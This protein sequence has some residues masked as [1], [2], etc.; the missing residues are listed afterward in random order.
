MLLRT[1]LAYAATAIVVCGVPAIA[2]GAQAADTLAFWTARRATVEASESLARVRIGIWDSGVDTTLFRTQLARDD[3]GHALIR[4]YD[5]FKRR[6]DTPMAVIPPA[7][8]ARQDE[9]NRVLQSLD[10]MD[11]GVQ[12]ARAQA[13]NARLDKLSKAESDLFEADI[14]RWSGYTH[15]TA[16]ADIAL[17]DGAP[18]ELIISRMEWWHGTPPVPCWTRALAEREAESMGGALAFLVANGARVVNMSWSRF[19]SGY[20]SNLASCAP[21]MPLAER[22]GLARFTVDTIRAVLREGMARAPH[23]LF[24]GASGNSGSTISN[25]NSGTRFAAPNFLLVGAADRL[26]ATASFSNTGPEV[27]LYANGDRVLSRLPGGVVSYPSGT[28]M[29]APVVVNAAVR[30]L[31]VNPR[32]SG[33]EVRVLLEETADR[34]GTGHKVLHAA[35]AVGAVRERR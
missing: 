2:A 13:L 33:A 8:L 7:L 15:G 29:A 25:A 14:N 5:P 12:S 10:D 27:A 28:S 18:A 23:V 32:L 34:N 6:Q 1:T 3:S 35:R 16:V 17:A 26:G 31:A 19:E 9:L 4:G 21:D 22:Q 24:V 30:L 20:L 11:G